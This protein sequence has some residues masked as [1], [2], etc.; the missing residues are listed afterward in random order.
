[1]DTIAGDHRSWLMSRVKGSN[2]KPE[3]VVRQVAHALG[4]RFRLHA[5]DLPGRPDILF[6]R[7][8]IV[9]FV[10]GCFWHRHAGC[11]KTTMPKTRVEFWQ[12]KF[13]ANI[14]RDRLA[15]EQLQAAKW[16]VETVWECQTRS[17]EVLRSKLTD[18]FDLRKELNSRLIC[19]AASSLQPVDSVIKCL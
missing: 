14:A 3:I 7:H 1:M 12:R 10:H 6:P 11:K 18:V 2:T 4:L 13:D 16:R 5:K 15:E 9:I 19:T 17:Q 8:R